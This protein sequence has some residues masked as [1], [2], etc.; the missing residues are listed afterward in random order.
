MRIWCP[1][2]WAKLYLEVKVS[3]RNVCA[4]HVSRLAEV[5]DM[6]FLEVIEEQTP[7]DVSCAFFL[8]LGVAAECDWM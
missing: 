6:S 1:S 4:V 3:C 7:Q 2:V 5:G 8:S